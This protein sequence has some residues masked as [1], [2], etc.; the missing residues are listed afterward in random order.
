M[1]ISI[2]RV[3]RI[4][5]ITKSQSEDMDWRVRVIAIYKDDDQPALVISTDAAFWDNVVAEDFTGTEIDNGREPNAPVDVSRLM[6]KVTMD[7]HHDWV[8]FKFTHRDDGRLMDEVTC[9][10]TPHTEIIWKSKLVIE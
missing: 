2:H 3:E 9:F 4:E 1:S 6:E 10:T 7:V 8:E 5:V